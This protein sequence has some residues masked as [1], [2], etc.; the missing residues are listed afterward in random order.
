MSVLAITFGLISLILSVLFVI[1]AIRFRHQ[2]K[3]YVRYGFILGL[4]LL[5]LDSAIL[6][7]V[8][9]F[10]ASMPLYKLLIVDTIALI[11]MILFTCVGMYC[12]TLLNSRDLP[13]MRHLLDRSNQQNDL[14]GWEVI[15]PA[16]SIVILAVAYSFVLFKLTSPQMSEWLRRVS[17]EQMAKAGASMQP[18]LIAALVVLEFAFAEEIIF[19]LGIQN[20]L[21]RQFKL[22]DGNYWVAVVPTALLWSLAHANILEPEWVKTAQVFP[23]GL[24]LGFIC[25]RYGAEVCILIH[26]AFNLIMMFLAPYLI[27][28]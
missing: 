3:T 9:N 10:F 20:Y 17:E 25:R 27:A 11:K 8:P 24:A 16:A 7:L 19:R 4:A 15:I 1:D 18:S 12:C 22:K 5:A 14:P 21:A 6:P 2:I 28:T 13:L 26:G 23:L